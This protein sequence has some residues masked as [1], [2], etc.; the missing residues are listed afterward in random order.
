MIEQVSFAGTTYNQLP[1]K[2]E[3]GTPNIAGAVGLAAAVDFLQGIDRQAADRHERELLAYA[4]SELAGT[5]GYRQIGEAEQR[6]AVLSFVSDFAHP[7]DI[8]MIL[9]QQ[10][11][12]VRTGNHCAQPIMD[13][14]AIPGTVRASFSLYN[15]RD[16]VDRLIAG[17]KKAKMFLA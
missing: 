16:D 8:G 7:Q 15:T 5:G 13:Q 9:D 12:A 10:G 17:L 3:A 14:F 1:Y 6:I 11:I 2:F 4:Q